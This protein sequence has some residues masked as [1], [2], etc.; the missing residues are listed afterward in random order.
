MAEQ[1]NSKMATSDLQS[2]DLDNLFSFLS[3][4]QSTKGNQII[5]EIGEQM[6][7]LVEDLDVELETVIQQEMELN[8]KMESKAN[9]P[10]GQEAPSPLQQAGQ[11]RIPCPNTGKLGQPSLPEPTEPPPPPP[12]PAAALTMNGDSST[13]NGEPI[14]ESVLPRE[15]NSPS[16]P[17]LVNGNS[18]SLVNGESCGS[19]PPVPNNKVIKEPVAGSPPSR[20]E[21]RNSNSHHLHHNHHQPVPPQQQ[22]G[23][24]QQQQQSQQPQQP[25]VEREQ[26]RK[27]RVERKLQELEDK[28]EVDNEVT[29]HDIVEFAQNYFNSHERSPEGTIMA[30]LTRKSR[31]KSVEYIPKYEM[32]TYYKGSTIPNSHIHMYDP[33]NV[34]V[35]C[36]VFRVSKLFS[37]MFLFL[38]NLRLIFFSFS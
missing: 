5:E 8:S 32:V 14:Y 15:E 21:S 6:D 33:D 17:I 36:S 24:D 13:D 9:T 12:P 29:Y 35:A 37:K 18:G 10:N 7:A 28:K 26:R 27:C 20:P 31:G 30:T 4:V 25:P 1:M 23:H 2:V 38:I 16:S 22:N 34:N 3:D 11:Q 19:P